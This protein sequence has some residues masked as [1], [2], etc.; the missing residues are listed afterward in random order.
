MASGSIDLYST[1][2]WEG[3]IYWES[4]INIAGNYSDVYVKATMWKTDGYLT[5]SN[6]YTSGNITIDGDNYSLI[7]YQEFKNEVT[8]FED[9][10][11]I[12]HDADGTKSFTISLSCKGQASTSLSG[13]TLSGSGT[14][15]MDTIPRTS[16]FA[17]T[18]AAIGS[19]STITITREAST[20]YH[21][22]KVQFGTLTGY[23]TNSGGFSK[24]A[25]TITGT[26]VGFTIPNDFYY[27]IPD[28]TKG[29]CT[30]TLYTLSNGT[31][32]GDAVTK[33]IQITTISSRCNP[34]LTITMTHDNADTA[35]LTGSNT[36]YIRGYS[37]AKCEVAATGRY[38]ATIKSVW[39]DAEYT[40]NDD[41]TYTIN[42]VESDKI[43]FYAKDS[44]GYTG[45]T[46]VSITL[47]PYI[48][49]TNNSVGGRDNP[50]DGSAFLQIK[51]DYFA[52]NFGAADN[53]LEIS[54]SIVYP[55]GTQSATQTVTPAITDNSYSARIDF[56][57]FDYTKVYYAHVTVK[58]K[59]MEVYKYVTIKQ[60]IPV[61]DW[62]KNDFQFHVPVYVMGERLDPGIVIFQRDVLNFDNP[63]ELSMD[64]SNFDYIEVFYSMDNFNFQDSVKVYN[65][66][67]RYFTLN[68]M[69]PDTSNDILWLVSV[70]MRATGTSLN[71]ENGIRVD[72][73]SGGVSSFQESSYLV[74]HKVVGYGGVAV[75]ALHT[76]YSVDLLTSSIVETQPDNT[77]GSNS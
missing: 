48:V 44:R 25:S 77:V 14:A 31:V 49:L 66:S 60:G 69:Y 10:V 55:D 43:T 59:L 64:V 74:V 53:T 65:P 67:G 61:F 27:E 13:V 12:Y 21:R 22:I 56:T 38:G 17:A 76:A 51:G 11:R 37:D 57:G 8:I 34:T 5:S 47:V 63:L 9:T 72:L 73:S 70:G 50:T 45:S 7:G 15:T 41:G 46:S 23:V 26:S 36:A 16:T 52:D 20:L 18:D 4:T 39:T 6:S 75:S 19:V 40:K 30:L 58:D 1:K 24:S 3:E 29:T 54:Y 32:V 42:P 68:S 62:G 2:A 33:T 71:R 28:G 35:A